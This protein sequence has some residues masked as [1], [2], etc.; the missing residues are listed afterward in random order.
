VLVVK[1]LCGD[2]DAAAAPAPAAAGDS[3]NATTT[4]TSSSSSVH[5]PTGVGSSVGSGGNGSG[6]GSSSSSIESSSSAASSQQKGGD[7]KSQRPSTEQAAPTAG[8]TEAFAQYRALLAAHGL[9]GECLLWPVARGARVSDGLLE[10]AAARRPDILA[11]GIGNYAGGKLGSVS[12]D[13]V[14]KAAWCNTLVIKDGSVDQGSAG[15]NAAGVK[16]LTELI[17]PAAVLRGGGGGNGD[18]ASASKR[19]TMEP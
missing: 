18:G 16:T 7:A 19:V 17:A 13:L 1:A 4:T 10:L 5:G 11:V 6:G 2:A 9:S 8:D 12:E 15:I 14:A 3:H